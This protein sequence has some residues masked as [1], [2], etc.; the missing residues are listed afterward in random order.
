MTEK[1]HKKL[2]EWTP[3]MISWYAD[4]CEYSKNDRNKKI[5]EAVI[6]VLP[7]HPYVCDIGCGIGTV[8][9]ELTKRA[10]R[11]TAIDINRDALNFLRETALRRGLDNLEIIEG[12]FADLEPP[13]TKADCV[14]FCMVRVD[15]LIEKARLWTAG[16]III[17][18]NP[19]DY[20]SFSPKTKKNE[21]ER[22]EK[23]RIYLKEN[24]LSY[25]ENLISTSSG[26]PFRNFDSAVSFVSSYDRER[27]LNDI[28]NM[29][30]ECL[31]DTGRTDFPFYLPNNKDY[32]IFT[33]DL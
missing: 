18:T 21:K 29:L 28:R 9:L 5:A 27:S 7:P 10:S 2:F 12:N 16:K 4:S 13:L 33:V 14:V 17:V 6:D 31:E 24:R 32:L 19:A 3:E 22:I 23:L 30:G 1:P 26:Q 15:D 20:H 11:V 25:S 8:S